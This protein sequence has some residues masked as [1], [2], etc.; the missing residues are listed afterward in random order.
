METKVNSG[1]IFKNDKKAKE[2]H[3]DYRG[4]VNV[5]GKDF[6]LS[7]WIKESK[8]GLK[9]FSVAVSEPWVPAQNQN[10]NEEREALKNTIIRESG[11]DNDDLPF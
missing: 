10:Q 9:Y 2:T 3:P 7:L 5:E 11:F 1:A 4:K 8:N 6:E